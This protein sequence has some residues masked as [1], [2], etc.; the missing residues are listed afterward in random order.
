MSRVIFVDRG[1]TQHT[2]TASNGR[3]IMQAAR[4]QL[5]PYLIGECGG[6]CICAS[7]HAYIDRRW[8]GLLPPVSRNE[9]TML[10]AISEARYNSRL[11]CQLI[12]EDRL[13]GVIVRIPPE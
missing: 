8:L 12:M 10:D 11:T 13:D 7:C 9:A 4:D 2:V 3:S 5:A 1:G 6:S